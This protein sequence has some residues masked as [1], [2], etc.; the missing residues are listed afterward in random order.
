MLKRILVANLCFSLLLVTAATTFSQ[1]QQLSPTDT[2]R[3]FY[4]TMRAKKFKEAFAM[5]IYKPAVEGLSDKELEDLRPDF[6]K[7]AANIPDKIDLTGETISG[8]LATVFV[9]VKE[10]TEKTEQP[11]PMLLMKINGVWIIG[12]K[13]NEAIVKK[14]GTNFF[15]IARIDTHHNEVQ[16]LLT[17]ITLAQVVY[18][19]QHNGQFGNLADLITA[20][21]LPK[22]LEGTESTGYSFHVIKSADSKSWYATAEPAQY[23][24]SGKLS[25]YLDATGVKSSD[26]GGKPLI[27]RN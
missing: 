20:G 7:M 26:V 6:E 27:V 14:A 9:K 16:D 22:D 13:E 3:L 19:Q 4:Q 21:F 24:R 11:E 25:F 23:G 18:S 2:V 15:F 5:S 1:N 17:K 8:D 10:T 12:D